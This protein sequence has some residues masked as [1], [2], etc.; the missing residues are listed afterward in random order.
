[1]WRSCFYDP[2][3]THFIA[4][5]FTLHEKKNTRNIL[6][7]INLLKMELLLLVAKWMTSSIFNHSNAC[8][9]GQ[10]ERN[11]N[12]PKNVRIWTNESCWE[13]YKKPCCQGPTSCASSLKGMWFMNNHALPWQCVHCAGCFL[14]LKKSKTV[15][16]QTSCIW[17]IVLSWVMGKKEAFHNM[18]S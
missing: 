6:L 16:S 13:V 12:P 14:H 18:F 15:H 5:L 7:A 9:Q 1:M 4:R 17:E 11:S 2:L 8:A 3:N 10:H